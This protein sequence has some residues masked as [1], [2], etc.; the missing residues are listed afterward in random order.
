MREG[1]L[2]PG[3]QRE[4]SPVRQPSEPRNR[5]CGWHCLNPPTFH[6]FFP[7]GRPLIQLLQIA[8]PSCGL[9]ICPWRHV[10]ASK[11]RSRPTRGL[12]MRA[13]LRDAW[14]LEVRPEQRGTLQLQKCPHLHRDHSPRFRWFSLHGLETC[15]A[16]VRYLGPE[17]HFV[18]LLPLPVP[19]TQLCLEGLLCRFPF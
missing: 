16:L 2:P 14:A 11:W 18:S 6:C 3:V 13:R 17:N 7:H 15:V 1:I 12:F 19:S 4:P 5:I 10:V 9:L 8:T